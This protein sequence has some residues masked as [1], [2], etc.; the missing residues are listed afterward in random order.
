MKQQVII[1]WRNLRRKISRT[2]LLAGSAGLTAFILFSSY[3]F[4]HSMERSVEAS[5]SRMGADL[6]VVPAGYGSQAGDLILSGTATP[7]YMPDEVAEQI[8]EIPEVEQITT[9]LYLET[10]STI[11]CRTEGDFP[12]VAFDPKTDF[13]L[14]H[15]MA[16]DKEL[17]MYE[18]LI[19]SEAG[20]KNFIYHY[21]NRYVDEWVTLFGKDFLVK[22]VMFP[23]GMGTD[24]TIFM[25]IDAARELNGKK[26]SGLEFPDSQI[27]VIL[28]KVRPGLETF[29]QGKIERMNLGVDVAQGKGLQETIKTQIFPVKLLSYVMIAM[30]LIM[31]SLQVMTMFTAL[32]SERRKEI[33]MLRAMGATRFTV[34][35]LLLFE[36]GLAAFMGASI[37][38]LTAGAILYDNRI[39]IMQVMQL[40]LLF[41]RWGSGVLIGLSVTALT[42]LISLFAVMIP[43]RSALKLEPYEAIREGE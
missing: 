26:G 19:G 11:C 33:G 10:V 7:F 40:P 27:S 2:A 28:L 30:V 3:F 43:I 39:F 9:Q 24:H 13:T 31:S 41:P 36:A 38:S 6:L 29:V 18:I 1:A 37:G 16:R 17:G 22:G 15:W 32:I 4:I 5:S 14:K 34:Y 23:T 20:G 42:V 8:S 25:T 21:D 35:R 12:I